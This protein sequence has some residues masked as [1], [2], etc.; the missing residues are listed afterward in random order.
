MDKKT[1]AQR[2][3]IT[4]QKSGNQSQTGL[5]AWDPGCVLNK[6][7][8]YH[9]FECPEFLRNICFIQEVGTVCTVI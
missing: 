8:F 2:S 5:A 3:Q 7:V 9:L 1:E 6:T 4:C